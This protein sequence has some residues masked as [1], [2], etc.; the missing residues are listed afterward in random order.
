MMEEKQR[1]EKDNAKLR[2][3]LQKIGIHSD[4]YQ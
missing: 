3:L 1:I 4:L 2:A